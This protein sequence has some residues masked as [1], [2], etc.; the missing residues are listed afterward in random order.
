G[1][2]S[3]PIGGPIANTRVYVLDGAGE[4]VPVGVAGELYVGGAGVARGYA[5]R[6]ALTAERF[7]P[8]PFSSDPGARLY[9]TGDVVRW[10]ESTHAL[11]HSRTHALEFVGRNDAQV[12]V[13]GF[14][15]ELGEI[16]ARL[17]EH[18][19]VRDAVVIARE[20]VPG[21]R[22]LVAY[23]VGDE[24]VE[25]E[26]LRAH[27]STR[28]PEYMVPAAY[29]RLDALPLTP[30]GKLDRRALPAP[31]GDAYA[32]REY[33]A[34]AGETETA[35]AAIWSDV[36]RVE[37]VGRR[38]SFFELG[39]HSLTA[40]QVVSRVRQAL[41]AEVALADVFSHPTLEALAGRVRGVRRQWAADRAIPLRPAGTQRPLFLVHEGMGSVAYAQVLHPHVDAGIPVYA[42][43]APAA[44]EPQPRT[45]EGMA[46]RLA[47]MVREVQPTGPYR[48]AGWSFGGILAYETAAQLMGQD[49][50][51]EFVGI[52][53]TH[54]VTGTRVPAQERGYDYGLLLSMLRLAELSEDGGDA[55]L[56]EQA[57]AAAGMDLETFVRRCREKGL[58]PGHATAAQ[59]SEMQNRLWAHRRSLRGWFPQPLP[60]PVHFFPAQGS[61]DPDPGRGW[62]ALLPQASMR[63]TPVPGTH[64]SM[65]EAGNVARLGE[66]LSGGIRDAAAGPNAPPR[67]EYAP[68]VTLRFG[69][70]GGE[71]LFCVPGAGASAASFT[72]LAGCLD[73]AR[74][75]H[76]FQPRGLEGGLPHTTVA[77]AAES[78]LQALQR[79]QPAGPVHLLGHSFGGWVAL[80]MALRLSKAGRTV[81]SLAILDSEVPGEDGNRAGEYDAR[82]AFLNLVEVFELTAERSLGIVPD[83]IAGLDEEGL[84]ALLHGRLVP[85]GLLPRRSEP[86]VLRG[87]LRTFAAAL[88]SA[89]TPDEPYPYPLDLVMLHDPRYNP[90][91]NQLRMAETVRL[92]R[93]WAPALTLTIGTGSHVTALKQPHVT[94]L[95]AHL[96]RVHP[97]SGLPSKVVGIGT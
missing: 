79:V 16:E 32:R 2:A 1:Q 49:Q 59:A 33:E 52:I 66:A 22:R 50:A 4:P 29:V 5:N 17:R 19:N 71:P 73:P 31:E 37:R 88:R 76:A 53:D 62:Q 45:V 40:V 81:G 68:L 41:G 87:T 7:V 93:R 44:A 18:E 48:L 12:K 77:A 47:R 38:D 25:V 65:M 64:L 54:L 8:D 92:W 10:T 56:E 96:A 15:V 27:L 63:V 35:L 84:L 72:D 89:W 21:D 43:P 78:Y 85:L 51:V 24:G 55:R 67:E 28:L 95:A 70:A 80:E 30:S 75:V 34:P 69:G 90:E 3:V 97:F 26:A 82:E 74:P 9:R 60:V 86:E 23:V 83:E 57:P 94:G 46:A 61:A 6:A 14:R 36:L 58:L 13:R 11:T 42:L 39:G 20:D 91:T